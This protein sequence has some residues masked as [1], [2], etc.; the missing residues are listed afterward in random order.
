M[1]SRPVTMWKT[2]PIAQRRMILLLLAAI[3]LANI[4][5]PYPDLAPLQH[6]PT[7]ALI[8]ATPW[9]LRRWPLSTSAVACIWLFLLLH[10]LG[11]R[12]IYSYVPYDDW[13][14]AVSG[15][16]IS[17]F[18]G[19][20]RNGYDRLVHFSFGALL[21]LPVAEFARRHGGLS[22][23]WSLTFAF[24]A[25]GLG[26]ALYEIFEWLLTIMAAGETADYYNGQ[27]GDVWDAQ[28][29]M[30]AAQVGS[31]LALIALLR[32]RG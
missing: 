31:G 16:D 22:W 18:F 8:M 6:G 12:W 3:G 29:D 24:A 19:T 5:Q 30:A 4:A 10:T 1:I 23:G 15:H 28:K 20:T 17:S 21:T 9:L 2:L 14:R 13:A 27:Q 11:A 26:S 7:I 32:L 25:I